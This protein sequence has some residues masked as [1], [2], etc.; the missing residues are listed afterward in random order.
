MEKLDDVHLEEHGQPVDILQI[1]HHAGGGGSLTDESR[2]LW[3]TLDVWM[4]VLPSLEADDEPEFGL[5]TTSQAPDDSVAALLRRD[6][7]RNAKRAL[8]VL[9][10]VASESTVAGTATVRG[11]FARL[12]AQDQERLV[13]AIVVRDEEPEILDLDDRLKELLRIGVRSEHLDAFIDSLKG[14]WYSRSVGLLRGSVAAVTG[15]DLLNRIHD[16]RD[17]YH[18]ENLPFDFDVALSSDEHSS[19]STRIFIRQ[20]QI[21]AATNDLLAVAIDEY[22]RAYT[23]KSRWLRLGLLRPGELD[24]YERKLVA[25]WKRQHA[26]MCAGLDETAPEPTRQE[27]G[28]RLWRELSDTTVVRIRPRFD[29]QELTRG[30]YHDLADRWQVGWHPTFEERLRELLD[31]AA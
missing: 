13:A 9:R 15:G 10:R 11:R 2:D 12:A 17:S 4:D 1:K 30:T 3:R 20:L 29:E 14:W 22:H 8:A 25:E 18:P 16:L 26:F 23:N 5:V 27:A 31:A 28:L 6:D 21:V 7:Q 19:Y 24:E